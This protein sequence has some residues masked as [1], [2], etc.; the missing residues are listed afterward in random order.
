MLQC[1][2]EGPPVNQNWNM[3]WSNCVAHLSGSYFHLPIELRTWNEDSDPRESLMWCE[4]KHELEFVGFKC[5]SHFESEWSCQYLVAFCH[6]WN[7]VICKCLKGRLWRLQVTNE[8]PLQS[9]ASSSGAIAWS[10]R[11]VSQLGISTGSDIQ[12]SLFSPVKVE[13]IDCLSSVKSF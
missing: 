1:S 8:N 3:N 4:V 5:I 9:N 12:V 13:D 7:S 6:M 10:K 2:T 11:D